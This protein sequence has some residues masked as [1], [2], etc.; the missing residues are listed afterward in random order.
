MTAPPGTEVPADAPSRDAPPVLHRTVIEPPSGWQLLGLRELWRYRE[1]LVTFVVRDVKVRY[2]QTVLG[3]AW[4]VLQPAMT[5][6]VFTVL[7]GTL[8]KLP[9]GGVPGPLFYLSGLLPW[10]FFATAVTSAANSVLGSGGLI[11]KVYFPRLAVPLSAVGA[12]AVDFLIACGLLAV[13]ALAYGVTPTWQLL[14]APLVVAIV[15]LFALGLGTGFAALN[16]AFRDFRYVVPFCVQL[17]MYATP[18]VFLQPTGDETGPV[19]YLIHLNPLSSLV[20]AFRAATLGGDIPW[21]GVG[22]AGLLA[23]L[24]FLAGCLYFRRVEDRFADII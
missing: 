21:A 4:A 13:M 14:A 19:W 22:V 16:V 23:V 2:K 6:A 17:G 24:T 9:T 20:T 18:T 12:A 15:G 7:F 10:F 5:R 3:A 11:T 1:L 8:A